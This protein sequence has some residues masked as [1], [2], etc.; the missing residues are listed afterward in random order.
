MKYTSCGVRVVKT[1]VCMVRLTSAQEITS[2]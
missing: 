2:M 1:S